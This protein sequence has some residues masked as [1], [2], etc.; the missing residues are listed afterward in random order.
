MC[1]TNNL[2]LNGKDY[3]KQGSVRKKGTRTGQ[4]QSLQERDVVSNSWWYFCVSG[5]HL[6][7]V[8]SRFSQFPGSIS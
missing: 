8:L 3:D 4:A 2:V 7:I 1:S 6:V 5:E